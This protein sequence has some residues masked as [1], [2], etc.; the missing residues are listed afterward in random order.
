MN[1]G[2][3]AVMLGVS[4]LIGLLGLIAFIWGLRTG[5]FDDEKKFTQGL[6]IDGVDELNDAYRNELKRESV[7]DSARDL[8][9]QKRESKQIQSINL[10]NGGKNEN[11]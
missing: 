7:R 10:N 5:Q 6:L 2:M 11:L 4:L 3:I 8:A 1:S 9:I